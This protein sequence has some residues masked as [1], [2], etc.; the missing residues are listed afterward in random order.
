MNERVYGSVP[1]YLKGATV[2]V[3]GGGP[4]LKG[5]DFARIRNGPMIGANDGGRLSGAG[6]IVTL[7]RNYFRH[8][9]ADL[10]E[11]AKG[12]RRAFVCLP[13]TVDV[14]AFPPEVTYLKFHRGAGQ[15]MSRNPEWIHGLNSG[16]AA[17]NVAYLAGASEIRLLGFDFH[18]GRDKQHWH[19]EHHWHRQ[20]NDRQIRRWARD[21]DQ[22]VGQLL[23]DDVRVFN[24]VGPEGS[25]ITTFPTR[26]L[27]DLAS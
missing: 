17:L 4:S 18:F 21:F 1:S 14:P 27:E 10:V 25:A 9:S 19:P 16:F 26:S 23:Q 24:Y 15:G 11:A 3:I 8:R 20:T 22:A 7:D 13:H 12:G 5:F 2:Y 6:T